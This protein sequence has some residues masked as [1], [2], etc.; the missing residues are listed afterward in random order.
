MKSYVG[1]DDQEFDRY[2][3]DAR[4]NYKDISLALGYIKGDNVRGHIHGG[5]AYGEGKTEVDKDIW[6]AEAEYF[7][8]PWLLPYLR[9]EDMGVYGSP[10]NDQSRIIAGTAI[11]VRAN[12]KFIIEGRFYT[13]NE[14]RMEK[15]DD[16]R[17]FFRIDYAF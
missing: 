16:D 6:F 17:M 3:V 14:P 7:V 15:N 11:L 8:Y 4:V 2:G 12:V 9:Y 10:D 5:G 13:K 1:G